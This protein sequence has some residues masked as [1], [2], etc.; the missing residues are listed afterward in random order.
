MRE[1]FV[2]QQPYRSPEPRDGGW[3]KDFEVRLG[4]S[5]RADIILVAEE[6]LQ[7]SLLLIETKV[8][9]VNPGGIDQLARYETWINEN[10]PEWTV[11]KILCAQEFSGAAL[12][13][14][15]ASGVECLQVGWPTEDDDY[16]P[17]EVNWAIGPVGLDPPIEAEEVAV[18][19]DRVSRLL[20][21]A[22]RRSLKERERAPARPGV[23]AYWPAAPEAAT[24]LGLTATATDK[25]LW[26]E[27][28]GH[29]AKSLRAFAEGETG[30]ANLLLG[31]LGM[32]SDVIRGGGQHPC[33]PD[34]SSPG[35]RP[36]C[37]SPGSSS[38]SQL[39]FAARSRRRSSRACTTS[40]TR[41][42]PSFARRSRR[43]GFVV[44]ESLPLRW[45]GSTGCTRWRRSGAN[46][47]R[48]ASPSASASTAIRRR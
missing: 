27:P 25:P 29:I 37:R 7:P 13:A 45:T 23:I 9:A 38:T 32:A 12:E 4:R 47:Q 42:K 28:S 14:A 6:E 20:A 10:Q 26:I 11:R 21:E 40:T 8:F 33:P 22:P 5:N 41:T 36:T 16:G 3:L 19:A 15:A 2:E 39:D 17:A 24:M 48:P 18:E 31:S 44:Y 30:L 35:R 34:P 43:V 1:F 46:P